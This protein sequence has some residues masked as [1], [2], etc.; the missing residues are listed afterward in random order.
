MAVVDGGVEGQ[1][2]GQTAPEAPLVGLPALQ[3][4]VVVGRSRGDALKA[5]QNQDGRP[6]EETV[7]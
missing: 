4:V 6:S 5:G 1:E 2:R 7:R 3:V